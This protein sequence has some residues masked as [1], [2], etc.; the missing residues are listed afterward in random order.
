M[1]SFLS[2]TAALALLATAAQAT[3]CTIPTS[4]KDDTASIQSAFKSC[5]TGG[6]VV[7][8]KGANYY[9]KSLITLSGL[10]GT[11]VQFDGT[12]N[13]PAFSSSFENQGAYITVSGDSVHWSGSGTINGNGQGWYDA[14]ETNAPRVLSTQTSN[15]YFGG[16]KIIQAPRAH[17][18][19]NGAKNT[20]YDGLS[21]HTVSTSSNLAK[22]TDAF[23]VSSS[24]GIIIQNSN[25][26]NGDDCLA[27][28]SGVT[29]LTMTNVNCTGSHGFSIGSLGKDGATATVS[30]VTI[31]DCSCTDC[32]NGVRIKT[33]PGGKGTV[34]NIKYDNIRLDSA[35]NPIIITTHYC[36]NEQMSSC[37]AD[38]ASSLTISDVIINNVYGSVDGD[39]DPILN[40][41]CSSS[42]PCSDFTI[43]NINITPVTKTPKN[44]C[45]YLDGS[46]SI[47]YC[48]E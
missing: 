8:T 42:T 37:N 43:T 41:N 35:Q 28:N 17:M 20:V 24:S 14:K 11:T 7:F 29:N 25:V 12:L 36:D 33:W 32:Q 48:S 22:N 23:D 31:T 3:T 26:V 30:D 4:G 44:V 40:V 46:S 15:S 9:L 6:T 5:A 21:F 27:V 38:D 47:P 34:K 2:V 13:L 19:I 18:S 39:S 10:K 45:V 1:K 16:F